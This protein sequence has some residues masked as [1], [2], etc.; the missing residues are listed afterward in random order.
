MNTKLRRWF[1]VGL[2]AVLLMLVSMKPVCAAEL[3][4]RLG[5]IARIKGDRDNQLLGIGL[6]VGLAGTGDGSRSQAVSQML[7]NV[8]RDYGIALAPNEIN[9]RNSAVVSV[10]ATLPVSAKSGDKLDATVSAT[11]GAKSL[12]GGT[13]M[14]TP[15]YGAD[16]QVYAVAQGQISGVGISKQA[17]GS[18]VSDGYPTVGIVSGGATVE[19]NVEFDMEEAGHISLVLNNPDYTTASRVVDVINRVF[20]EDTAIALD[21]A[22]I[23]VKIPPVFQNRTVSFIAELQILPVTP[24]AIGRVVIN[25]RTGTVVIGE[26]VRIGKVAVSHGNMKV[27]V[28]TTKRVSQPMSLSQGS[29]EVVEEA[30]IEVSEGTGNT[31]VVEVLSDVQQLVDALNLIGASPRDVISILQEIRAAGALYGELIV[32]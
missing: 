9:P 28:T 3:Q 15:L 14:I 31:F 25:E 23:Q 26:N 22:E 30:Q 16:G 2:C 13:L 12:L 19:A 10:T 4:V 11:E 5:E 32:R 18:S 8:M 6:V 1:I 7:S 24:D 27:T 17:R 20:A 21:K 29:T